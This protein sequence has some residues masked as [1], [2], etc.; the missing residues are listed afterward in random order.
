MKDLLAKVKA[1]DE[2]FE[3]YP[4]SK[5]M[6]E[7]VAKDLDLELKGERFSILDI[8]AGNGNA[9]KVLCELTE[10]AGQKYAIEKSRVL[11]DSLP[12]DVFVIG[13]DFYQQTL[14]DKRVDVIFCN[15][16]YSD[17]DTWVTKIVTEANCQLIYLVIPERW[18][19]NGFVNAMINKR[20]DMKEAED[21]EFRK[22]EWARYRGSC[23]VLHST[24]FENSEFRQARAK[25]DIVKIKLKPS[26]R[27]GNGPSIDPFDIWF[28]SEFKIAA[29]RVE[30]S[31]FGTNQSRASRLH[32][33]V[34]GQNVVERLEELYHDD[35]GKL[36]KTYKSL[37]DLDPLL[38][39]ELGVNIEGMKSG[40]KGK[41]AGLKNLYW[42]ELFDNLDTITDRLTSKSRKK[43]LDTLMSH[44]SIDF[45]AGNAYAVVI[46]AIKNANKYFDEQLL[47]VYLDLSDQEN[48]RNYKSNHT[49][50][51]DGWRYARKEASRYTLDYRLVLNQWRCFNAE[52][53]GDYDYPNGLAETVHDKLND[54][55]TIAE[56]LGFAIE[57]KSM[58][59]QWAPGELKEFRMVDGA[60]FMD[61]RAYKKGTIHVRC[62]QDFM[63]KLNIEAGRLNGWVKSPQEAKEET[64]I[65]NAHELFGTNF[66]LKSIKM[67]AG[68][69]EVPQAKGELF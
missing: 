25:V 69:Q 61:V 16:P 33:L 22:R 67:L 14:I 27:S 59:F 36:L 51:D 2:D 44:A 42:K 6:L 10:N 43:L 63:R 68:V 55:C 40:L 5:T 39:K 15:P 41:I 1:A 3:W 48:V 8:G 4:T 45:T 32:E 66:K 20:C 18:K 65:E 53:Y 19:D 11:T 46:W 64:G 34:R 49:V 56:N 54:L 35:F 60:L 21:P 52:N 31:E 58:D 9:L 50:I 26:G 47:Q 37:E 24:T 12:D 23:E 7:V 62:N 29:D 13:T 28:D 30:P 57:T 17:F 38:L